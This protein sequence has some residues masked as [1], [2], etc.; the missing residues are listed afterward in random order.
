MT[1]AP[2]STP[3][4][5]RCSASLLTW[6]LSKSFCELSSVGADGVYGNGTREVSW[7]T[8]TS[9][10]AVVADLHRDAVGHR[11]EDI[12]VVAGG[13]ADRDERR[14]RDPGTDRGQHGGLARLRAATGGRDGPDPGAERGDDDQG[15]ELKPA[16]AGHEPWAV[17]G[18]S[19]SA[20]QGHSVGSAMV[21]HSRVNGK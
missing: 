15:G 5:F 20:L 7:F 12:A 18:T 9:A 8:Y 17:H 16:T 19:S 21:P 14:D 11:L 3:A 1:M 10:I 13:L 6:A 4:L 2:L